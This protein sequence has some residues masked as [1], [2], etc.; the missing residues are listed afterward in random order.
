MQK[1]YSPKVLEKAIDLEKFAYHGLGFKMD[2]LI[3]LI[4]AGEFDD[5]AILGGDVLN[6]ENG[7]CT[8]L[9]DN[10]YVSERLSEESFQDYSKRSREKTLHYLKNYQSSENDVF[11]IVTNSEITAGM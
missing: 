10:W 8:P 11:Q 9:Y 3:D 5:F 6:L 4:E 1:E 7:K 2:D